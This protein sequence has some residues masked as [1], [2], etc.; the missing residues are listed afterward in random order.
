MINAEKKT[1][2]LSPGIN[3]AANGIIIKGVFF[4]RKSIL[5][6]N[7]FF[8]FINHNIPAANDISPKRILMPSAREFWKTNDRTTQDKRVNNAAKVVVIA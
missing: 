6:K 2:I 3:I 1:M 4:A 7:N 5:S 8:F